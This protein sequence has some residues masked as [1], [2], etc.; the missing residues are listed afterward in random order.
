[1]SDF[2]YFK[3]DRVYNELYY[4]FPKVFLVSE[5]YRKMSDSTK[6]AYMLL[7]ARQAAIVKNQIDEEG[8]VYFTYTTKELCRVLNC[9]KQKAISIKDKLEE[10]GLLLQKDMGFNKKLGKQNPNRMYLA[11]LNVTENDIYMLEKIDSDNRQND[12]DQLGMNIIP[13]QQNSN[14]PQSLDA[15]KGMKIIPSQNVDKSEGMKIKQVLNNSSLQET[16][17]TKRNY[18]TPIQQK[19]LLLEDFAENM[20]ALN[21]TFLPYAALL[22]IE[23][24][25]HTFEEAHELMKAIH[26]AKANAEKKLHDKL[27]FESLIIYDRYESLKAEDKVT[28][29]VKS[30]FMAQ[31]TQEVRS[32]KGLM[33][34]W[35]TNCFLELIGDRNN[36]DRAI[37]E[38]EQS[39]DITQ[40]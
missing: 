15:Q 19:D 32:L 8:N 29:T 1:M 5:E 7:K 11:E 2:N 34:T 12:E 4:Q 37:A 25:S 28:R 3:A 9:Q 36:L 6:I 33:F 40:P 26:N 35:A 16:K 18:K 30:V 38:Q 21:Q 27:N 13:S 39:Q 23:Q 20:I 31:K 22:C 14:E 17:G 10:F 24:Y